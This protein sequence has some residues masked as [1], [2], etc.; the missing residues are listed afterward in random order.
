MIRKDVIE[1]TVE[2]IIGNNHPAIYPQF[3]IQ[4]L[5]KLLSKEDN[6]VLDPFV[7]SGTT[8]VVAKKLKRNFI[9]IEIFPGY[10]KLAEVRLEKTNVNEELEFIL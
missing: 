7:G 1:S 6:L 5:L 2:T 3:I 4:E 10:C 9:G 8:A